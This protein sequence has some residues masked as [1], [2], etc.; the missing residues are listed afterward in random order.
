[1][2][3]KDIWV[4][5]SIFIILIV[6]F[7]FNGQHDEPKKVTKVDNSSNHTANDTTNKNVS[8]STTTKKD[9]KKENI[10]NM[11][12]FSPLGDA[13]TAKF[14]STDMYRAFDGAEF[15]P[16]VTFFE[17]DNTGATIKHLETIKGHDIGIITVNNDGTTP[18]EDWYVI[19]K[20]TISVSPVFNRDTKKG[21]DDHLSDQQ[22]K[23]VFE[24]ILK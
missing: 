5:A 24:K 13:Y 22:F 6:A 4:A 8:T 2:N 10:F 20:Y 14:L 17:E 1:M 19:G 16:T 7:A 11:N 12:L 9:D 15:T 18:H 21:G 3:D 23:V